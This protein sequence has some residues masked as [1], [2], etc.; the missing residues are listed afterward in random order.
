MQDEAPFMYYLAPFS[1]AIKKYNHSLFRNSLETHPNFQFKITVG[2]ITVRWLT[3]AC[4]WW[5]LFDRHQLSLITCLLHIT[6]W[7]TLQ[8]SRVHIILNTV[9]QHFI[10]NFS[11]YITVEFYND[12]AT[13]MAFCYYACFKQLTKPH[14]TDIQPPDRLTNKSDW[15]RICVGITAV[16]PEEFFLY[17]WSPTSTT[18]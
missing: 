9:L 4:V 15:C 5:L 12:S 16:L 8:I 2:W 14:S 17:C 7:T 10:T 13:A 1:H 18:N 3:A 11:L 6:V